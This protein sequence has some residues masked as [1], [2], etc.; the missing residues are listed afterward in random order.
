MADTVKTHPQEIKK[1]LNTF[2]NDRRFPDSIL[3][4]I[5]WQEFLVQY[6]DSY[7][8]EI[9]EFVFFICVEDT[10]LK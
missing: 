7:L 5:L 4:C 9:I 6:I 8:T 3:K 2:Q 1:N 10:V